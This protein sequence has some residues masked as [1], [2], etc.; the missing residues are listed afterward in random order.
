MVLFPDEDNQG[1]LESAEFLMTDAAGVV[2]IPGGDFDADRD[3]DKT[4]RPCVFTH[5][6]RV[7]SEQ[8]G[9]KITPEELDYFNNPQTKT[10]NPAATT[11]D[12]DPNRFKGGVLL[13]IIHSP[14]YGA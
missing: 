1:E 2:Q 7:L 12:G 9:Y 3:L 13:I 6:L 8:V 11:I 5:A 14:Q 4:G 10:F